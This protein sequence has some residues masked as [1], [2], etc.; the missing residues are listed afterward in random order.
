MAHAPSTVQPAS[1]RA[2]IRPAVLGSLSAVVGSF[3]VGLRTF[4]DRLE[5][6][7]R[8]IDLVRDLSMVRVGVLRVRELHDH[9]LALLRRSLF[10]RSQDGPG[11]MPSVTD[12]MPGRCTA[13]LLSGA[14]TAQHQRYRARSS[15][16]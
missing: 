14:S 4:E 15:R 3:T 13:K 11:R 2:L 1:R 7:S 10:E 9:E 6:T 8:G 16:H 5:R 12:L